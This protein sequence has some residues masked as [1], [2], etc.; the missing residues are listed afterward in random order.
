MTLQN[1]STDSL[2]WLDNE[3][4]CNSFYAIKWI[5][6]NGFIIKSNLWHV[7]NDINLSEKYFHFLWMHFTNLMINFKI[8]IILSIISKIKLFIGSTTVGLVSTA[9]VNYDK[10]WER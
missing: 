6:T 2:H 5:Y 8:D 3:Q 4:V 9:L 10:V 1:Y 7:L